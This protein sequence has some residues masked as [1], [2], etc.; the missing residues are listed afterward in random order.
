MNNEAFKTEYVSARR[1]WLEHW[2]SGLNPMQRQAVLATEGPVLILAG[3]GS[4]KT[5][6]LI[7][8]I[9]NLL[10]FG[11]ASDS[12]QLPPGADEKGLEALR[13]LS[14]EAEPYAVLDPVRPWR[15]LA[16]TFT[17]KAAQ[18]LKSRLEK[19]LNEGADDIWACTFHSACLRILRKEAELLGYESGFSIYDT[20]DSQSLMKQILKDRNLDEKVY[21]PRSV[22]SEISRAKDARVLPDEYEKNARAGGNLRSMRVAELYGEYT[23]RLF[24]ANAMDFDDLILNTVLLLERYEDRRLYWQQRFSYIMVDEYQDTNHLQYLLISLLA[25]GRGNL[26]VVGD[27]DQSIYRFRGATIENILSFEQ[28]FPGCRSIRLEQNYRSTEEILDAANKVI[29]H[30]TGRKGKELWTSLGSGE[31]VRVCRL[32]DENEEASA[33]ASDILADYSRGMHWQ[34]HAILYRMNAQ[35]SQFE[36]AFKRN[37]IPYRVIGGARFFDRAEIKD[38]LSYLSIIQDPKDELRLMR[39]LNVP[40]RG[41]GAKSVETARSLA[42]QEGKPLF[43]IL[44]KAENYPELSRPALRMRE[45]A[46][47]IRD[48]QETKLGCAELYELVLEKT[49]Y[50]RM[51][52]ESKDPKDQSRIENVRELKTSMLGFE[53]E[54]GDSSLQAYLENIA[55]YTDLDDMDRSEDSVVLMTIHSAKGL[56]FPVVYVVG[57]EEGIFPGIRAIGEAD[58]MEEERRLCYVAFTRAKKKLVLTHARQRMLFGRTT[59][60]RVSRF[61]EESELVSGREESE[62]RSAARGDDWGGFRGE[63]RGDPWRRAPVQPSAGRKPEGRSSFPLRRKPESTPGEASATILNLAVGQAVTHKAF[64]KGTVT[65]MTPMGGD[66]LVEIQFESVGSKKLMLKTASRFLQPAD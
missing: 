32:Y 36:F 1:A 43:E 54:T 39:I 57:M 53:N 52:E 18:E 3:A 55:L 10:R 61:L 24:A 40:P 51:L 47:M 29:R 15:I 58:E 5:T 56:E 28:Q 19:L 2:F 6:V 45:F 41:I 38:M 65:K 59:A 62:R 66:H 11:A 23:R 9:A 4:G 48:L 20:A 8:R 7:Q 34:D 21:Q 33:V 12:E 63:A 13:S 44:E 16:I 27:D 42:L 31:D 37:G 60:N 50:L 25:G 46:G 35:S 17:N 30:N 26:C 14:P 49:G 64:G 22:L